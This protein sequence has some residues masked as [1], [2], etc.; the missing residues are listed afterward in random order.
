MNSTLDN[1]GVLDP[2]SKFRFKNWD[3]TQ[4]II[5]LIIKKLPSITIHFQNF[6]VFFL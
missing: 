4:F 6:L 2:F 1:A 5:L 3:A